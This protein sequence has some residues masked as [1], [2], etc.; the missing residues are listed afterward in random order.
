MLDRIT[1]TFGAQGPRR[2]LRDRFGM[3]AKKKEIVR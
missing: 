3:A 1:E 2:T